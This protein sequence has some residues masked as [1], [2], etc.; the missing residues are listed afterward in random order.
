M[1]KTRIIT[2]A[3]GIPILLGIAYMGGNYWAGFITLL[4]AVVL[5]EYFAMMR[6][7]GFQP[8]ILPA[9]LIAFIL[10]FRAQLSQN[11]VGLLFTGLLLMILSMVLRYPRINH[12]DLALS[13]FAAFY[14]GFLFSY[15]LALTEFGRSFHILLLIFILTWAS[16]VGGY[17]FGRLWGKNK[18]VPQLSPGKTWEGAIGAVLL[19]IIAALLYKYLIKMEY[20]GVVYIIMLGLLASVAAQLG[21]LLESSIKRYFGVKDSSQIIPG[22][23]GVMDRFDS[24]M[25]MLPVVYYFLVVFV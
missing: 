3:I 14:T 2:A 18:M 20:L 17:L 16:D 25:L 4:T 5:L 13:L 7:Q 23:G 21:D 11:L 22:H 9:F 15:A 19:T 12:S 6:H 8:I 10:L 24:F 1:L